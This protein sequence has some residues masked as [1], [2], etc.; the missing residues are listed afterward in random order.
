M[1]SSHSRLYIPPESDFIPRFFRKEP[2]GKLSQDQVTEL[3]DI[4]F[5]KYRF[6]E[7]WQG[8]PPDASSFF[9][10]MNSATP[11]GFLDLLY[12]HYAAQNKAIRWGDKT[13]IY[14]SYVDLLQAIFPQA[15]FIHIVRD[16]FDAAGSLL[17]KYADRE[18]HIDIYFAARNWVRR[19]RHIQTSAKKMAKDQILEVRYE[20]LVRNPEIELEKICSFLGETFETD[21]LEQYILAQKVVEPGSHFFENVR[22]PINTKSLG[23]GRSG[24]SEADR[25]VIQRVA[26]S[27]MQELGYPLDEL[28]PMLI[29]EKIR[30]VIL[31]ARYEILQLGRRA[32]TSLGLLPP[33]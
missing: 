18:F 24:L 27:L 28:G 15:K 20:E 31:W 32:A 9:D 14:A 22:K 3:L 16:P 19:I 8:V 25:R 5:T 29:T 13:P 2:H 23:R 7:D 30:F 26:G 12:G 4:I 21:M 10:Q 1:L 17:D 6:V 11:A 33:I